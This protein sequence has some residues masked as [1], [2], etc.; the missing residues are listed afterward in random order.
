LCKSNHLYIFLLRIK[1]Y[2]RRR[3]DPMSKAYVTLRGEEL[4]LSELTDAERRFLGGVIKAYEVG[5]AYP[6]F[7]NRVNAP[8]SPVLQG[9]R[10]VT[11]EVISSPLY[12]ICQDLADRLGVAQGF[13]ALGAETS[14]EHVG[15][16]DRAEPQEYLTCE[17][18]AEQAGVTAEA[19]RKAIRQERLSARRVGRI[20]LV[21]RNAVEAYALRRGRPLRT[22]QAR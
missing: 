22:A 19:I 20:Y 12:R 5:E 9:G 6:N 8:D 4:P 17:A 7:V 3:V 2:S 1:V 18:A 10:W 13:L 16:V 21:E 14:L 15:F 11:E